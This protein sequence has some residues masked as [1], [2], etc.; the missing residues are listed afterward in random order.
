MFPTLLSFYIFGAETIFDF[1]TFFKMKSL[2]TS[3]VIVF[4]SILPL[5]S[6][7][8]APHPRFDFGAKFVEANQTDGRALYG[9]RVS[10]HG[11]KS[12]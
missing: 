10:I 5:A 9:C 2:L 11:V 7:A 3:L 1:T 6:S 4:V 8:D 12:S